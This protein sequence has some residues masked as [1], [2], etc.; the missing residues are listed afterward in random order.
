MIPLREVIKELIDLIK[1]E[2][3]EYRREGRGRIGKE[4]DVLLVFIR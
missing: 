2:I 1:K 4:D 3:E